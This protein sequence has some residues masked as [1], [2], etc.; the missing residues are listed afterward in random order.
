MGGSEKQ[1][2]DRDM[3]VATSTKTGLPGQASGNWFGRLVLGVGLCGLGLILTACGDHGGEGKDCSAGTQAS[4]ISGYCIPRY[5]SLK[6]DT[7]SARGGPG[8]DYPILWQ[9]RA[10]GLP[11]QVVAETLDWRRVCDAY[12]G[13]VWVHKM[14]ID[15]RR[16]V[17][18]V[19]AS[20]VPVL[21]APRAGAPVEG[22]MKPRS[23][24]ELDRCQGGWCKLGL[25]GVEG[26]V[27]ADRLWGVAPAPQC[28]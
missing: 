24:A 17:Q 9:Y 7:V 4:T 2:C 12:G 1:L 28:R 22:L 8:T 27:A 13:A 20:P 21:R 6:R 15:G 10:K 26:W 11:V 3:G 14:M 19:G 23:L 18:A 25:G 16:S 5:V